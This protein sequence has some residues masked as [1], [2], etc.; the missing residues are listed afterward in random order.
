LAKRSSL[1][2]TSWQLGIKARKLKDAFRAARQAG[3][4]EKIRDGE[5]GTG[6]FRLADR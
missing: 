5:S 1:A 4:L 3:E 2:S 6:D